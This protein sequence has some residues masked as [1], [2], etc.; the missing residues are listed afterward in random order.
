MAAQVSKVID[1]DTIEVSL[2]GAVYRLRYIGIDAP[3]PGDA[4]G[5]QAALEAN[6]ALVQGK[7]VHLERDTSET[8]EYGR[9]LRYVYVGDL[10]VN[11][12]LVRLG[13]AQAKA[14]PPDV[15]Y[16]GLFGELERQAQE[17]KLGLWGAP[18]TAAASADCPAAQYEPARQCPGCA[19]YIASRE[20]EPFH[21]PWCK[22][23]QKISPGN[24][25]CFY[26]REEAIQA[27]HRPCKVCNP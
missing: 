5:G 25:Q 18:P 2:D 10:L 19:L 6:R 15:K 23:A 21:H 13:L 22:S 24:M 8:D 26:S 17:A 27:G 11:A 12:E 16:Q 3:E 4:S 1:G 7:T 9:L 20:R 14:Y